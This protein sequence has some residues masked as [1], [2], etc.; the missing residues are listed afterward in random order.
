MA[1]WL[2]FVLVLLVAENTIAAPPLESSSQPE[3]SA[4][5]ASAR[6]A[7]P[8]EDTSGLEESNAALLKG[9]ARSGA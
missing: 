7:L 6:E 8:G 1:R 5:E 3:V 2:S 4:E 9:T